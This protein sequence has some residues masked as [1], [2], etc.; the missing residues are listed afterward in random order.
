MS[1][2]LT[3]RIILAAAAGSLA[4]AALAAPPADWGRQLVAAARTQLGVTTIYDPSY[5]QLAYPGGDFDRQRG[6]CTDVVVRAYR[7][8]FGLDLQRLIHEDMARSF[9]AYPA[10][11][12]L[13]APNASIDHRRVPNMQ[14]FFRRQ[15]AE[16]PVSA[17][18][19]A[20]QEGDLVT[21]KLPGNLDHIMIVTAASAAGERPLIIHNIGDG[22]Q[23][24][25]RLF[26]FPHTGHYR[27]APP[28]A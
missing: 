28:G 8:A 2:P 26:E 1:T 6:V 14:V 4:R 27:Y 16:L 11:W 22:A 18:N 21:V 9:A 23:L 17:D 20:H 15:R 25:D 7:D 3:R 24:E 13:A 5:I 19:A 12:G 10:K